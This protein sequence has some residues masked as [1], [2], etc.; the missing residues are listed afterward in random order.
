MSYSTASQAFVKYYPITIT[1]GGGITVGG[2]T[3]VSVSYATSVSREVYPSIDFNHIGDGKT[4]A[5]GTPHLYVAWS[6]A[7]T[8]GAGFG[9]RFKKATYLDGSWTWGTER[10]IDSSRYVLSAAYPLTLFFDGI[11]VVITGLLY[12]GS[13]F[14]YV[15]HDR[16]VADTTTTLRAVLVN[17]GAVERLVSSSASYDSVG[18]VYMFG[19]NADKANGT[20]NLV[21]RKWTRSGGILGPQI[22]FDDTGRSVPYLSAKRG[23]SNNR[24][25]FLYIDNTSSP[26]NIRAGGIK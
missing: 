18:N 1:S 23:F 16:D 20:Q 14:S 24:I 8:A 9:T 17:P 6:A 15:I 10:E 21:Y 25:D 12:T 5:G 11:R 3:G 19:A 13:V 7:N 4:I 26:F 22:L 2:S